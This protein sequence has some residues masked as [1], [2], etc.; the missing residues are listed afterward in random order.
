MVALLV[1]LNS[2]KLQ[3]VW[4]ESLCFDERECEVVQNTQGEVQ[5]Y[6]ILN[7]YFIV[8]AL[9]VEWSS[10]KYTCSWQVVLHNVNRKMCD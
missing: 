6:F 3:I 10:F 8:S 5:P 1:L 7:L 9:K 4:V 2:V